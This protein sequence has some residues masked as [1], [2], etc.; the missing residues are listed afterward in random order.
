VWGGDNGMKFNSLR[1]GG[2]KSD[3]SDGFTVPE[4]VRL[5]INVYCSESEGGEGGG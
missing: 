3:I 2:M 1:G 4:N 5:S